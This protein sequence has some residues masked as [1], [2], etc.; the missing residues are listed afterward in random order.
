MERHTKLFL[1]TTLDVGLFTAFT[2]CDDQRF[3]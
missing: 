2:T 1:F 3:T